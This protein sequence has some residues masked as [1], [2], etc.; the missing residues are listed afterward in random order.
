MQQYKCGCFCGSVQFEIGLKELA[1]TVCHCSMCRKLTGSTGFASVEAGRE[2]RKISDEG[3]SVF[4]SSEV[5]ERGFCRK[6]GT[7][8]FYHYKPTDEYFVP[9]ALIEGL[10][11]E[12]VVFVEEIYY[13]NKPCYYAYANETIKKDE[14]FFQ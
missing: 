6:C 2:F 5:G 4:A 13:D 9:P 3:L 12:D 7:S 8:L 10:P 1:L 11:E 14:A